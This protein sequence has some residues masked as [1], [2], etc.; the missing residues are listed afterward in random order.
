MPKPI[1]TAPRDGRKVTVQWRGR[2]GVESSSLAQYRDG[3]GDPTDAG[4]WVFVDSETQ[5]RV[6]PHSWTGPEDA[7][8]E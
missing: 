3:A 8:D 2:D 4:W 7:E 1:E 5:K 6:Q